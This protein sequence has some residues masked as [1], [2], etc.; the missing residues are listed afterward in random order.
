MNNNI[1]NLIKE[2][3]NF[4]NTQENI[5]EDSRSK[6]AGDDREKFDRE[7]HQIIEDMI[8]EYLSGLRELEQAV[9]DVNTIINSK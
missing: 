9:E 3:D 1:S 2:L 6:W 4:W 7:K 5:W 8:E